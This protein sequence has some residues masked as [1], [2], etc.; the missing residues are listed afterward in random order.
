MNLSKI[1]NSGS[2]VRYHCTLIDHKQNVAEHSWE[3][4]V[5]LKRIYPSCSVELMLYALTHDCGEL[6]TGDIAA[7]VKKENPLVKEIFDKMEKDYVENTL[8]LHHPV[9]NH[10]EMLAIKHADVLSGLYFTTRRIKCGDQ[11]AV[12]I[13]DKWLK[14][15]NELPHLNQMSQDAAKEILSECK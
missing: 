1:L 5:I 8:D 15:F 13:R 4:A 6:M 11:N 2:V 14:Y 9:F 10:S 3:T 7:P 12:P